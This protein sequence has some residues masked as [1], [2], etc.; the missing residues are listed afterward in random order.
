MILN[1]GDDRLLCKMFSA[2]LKGPTLA[3][4]HKLPRGSINTFDELWP[5]SFLSTCALSDKKGTSA[6][7]SPSLNGKKSPSGTSSAGSDERSNRL[8][9]TVWMQYCKTSEEALGQPP[10]SSSLYPLTHRQLWRNY[11]NGRINSLRWK[12]TSEPPRKPS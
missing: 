5:R 12:I 2:I 8:M 9:P 7:S 4:F 1:V 11:I 3:W 6:P 10:R